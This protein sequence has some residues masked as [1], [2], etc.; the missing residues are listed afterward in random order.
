MKKWL[1][2]LLA[3][4]LLFCCCVPAFAASPA[5]ATASTPYPI[6]IARGM[7]FNGLYTNYGTPAQRNCFHG[8]TVGGVAKALGKTVLNSFTMGLR[9][10]FAVAAVD[11]VR[12]ILGDMA[13]DENG[14]SVLD[15]GWDRYYGSM[16]QF[17]EFFAEVSDDEK[18]EDALVRTA[19]ETVGAENVY[20]YTY[21]YRLDPYTLADELKQ[22]IDLASAEHGGSKVI[23]VNCSM[24]GVIT[25]CY[26]YKYGAEDLAKVLFLSS[27][28]CGTDEADEILRGMVETSGRSL[29]NYLVGL[30]GDGLLT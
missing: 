5:P 7:D 30:L 4:L 22:W 26:L 24:A 3:A 16:A 29:Y 2:V 6:V 11:Y 9:H 1:S 28:F 10:G 18:K 8:L 12:E 14:E 27:T 21:D 23:L 17:P 15:V 13:C 20:Y 19:A 25:D